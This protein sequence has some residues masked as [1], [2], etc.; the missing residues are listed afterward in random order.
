MPIKNNV[1]LTSKNYSYNIHNEKCTHFFPLLWSVFRHK[2]YKCWTKSIC[3][4]QFSNNAIFF[5]IALFS[6]LL[7]LITDYCKVK[8]N[9]KIL[10]ANTFR[11]TCQA[12]IFL[13]HCLIT[14]K[15]SG[16]WQSN[17]CLL[18]TG[19]ILICVLSCIVRNEVFESYI[20]I[21]C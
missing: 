14:F 1:I 10:N 19:L 21:K 11:K 13:T 5:K 3:F 7:K 2:L 20:S 18:T 4:M 6:F 17:Y 12:S 16:F 9:K 8:S 15:T